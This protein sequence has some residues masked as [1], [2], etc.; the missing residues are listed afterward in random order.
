MIRDIAGLATQAPRDSG[1]A[2]AG[3][4]SWVHTGGQQRAEPLNV[5]KSEGTADFK[6]V[7]Q[8]GKKSDLELPRGRNKQNM[9]V[10][11]MQDRFKMENMGE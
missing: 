3:L 4:D 6:E 10:F 2:L 1:P 5:N 8:T 9:V 7:G 11:V